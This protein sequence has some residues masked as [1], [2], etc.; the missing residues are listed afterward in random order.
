MRLSSGIFIV[1]SA[2]PDLPPTTPGL[3]SSGSLLIIRAFSRLGLVPPMLDHVNFSTPPILQESL[4]VECMLSALNLLLSRTLSS[5]H[6]VPH[7]E[8]RSLVFRMPQFRLTVPM[9]NFLQMSI[10]S[11]LQSTFRLDASVSVLNCGHAE[12]LPPPQATT[13]V[14][15]PVLAQGKT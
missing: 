12:F 6:Q 10:L 2:H 14:N 7:S 4:C 8:F 11:L 3:V 15:P 13:C 1:S 9:P 5:S